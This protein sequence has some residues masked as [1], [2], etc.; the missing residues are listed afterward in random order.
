MA[1]A[2]ARYAG[3]LY[4]GTSEGLSVILPDD[5]VQSSVIDIARDGT[6][7]LSRLGPSAR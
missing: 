3:R 2:I 4:V 1:T 5:T 6:F 7:Q